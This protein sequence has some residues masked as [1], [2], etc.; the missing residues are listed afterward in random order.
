M[1]YEGKVHGAIRLAEG[2]DSGG[3]LLG[4]KESSEQDAIG[5]PMS[6][7]DSHPPCLPGATTSE[8][9]PK[10]VKMFRLPCHNRISSKRIGEPYKVFVLALVVA[11]TTA[12]AEPA[13]TA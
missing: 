8:N 5:L 2:G 4:Y 9:V 10:T 11:S 7:P 3:A 6:E 1:Q 12:L 13:P